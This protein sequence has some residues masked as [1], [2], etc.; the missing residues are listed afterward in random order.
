M[1]R[2]RALLSV[3]DKSGIEEFARGLVR[4]GWEV[5]S[6][7]G[8][9]RALAGAGLPVVQVAEVTSHPEMMDGRVKTLHPAVH[10]GI[11]ARGGN[12]DDAAAL[13]GQGYA[14]VGLVAVNLYPFGETVAKG[15]VSVGDAMEQVD[16]GGPTMIR[17]AA[18]NHADVW[19]VVDPADYPR[20]LAALD[21]EADGRALRRELAVKVFAHTSAYDDAVAVWLEQAAGRESGTRTDAGDPVAD[22][23]GGGMFPAHLALSAELE[24]TLRYGENPDQEA[25]FYRWRGQ[26]PIGLAGLEQL[27]GK[28]LSYNN[29]LDLDGALHCLAPFAFSAR[30]AVCIVKHTTPAGMALAETLEEAYLRAL[31]TDPVSAF[32]SVI[33]VNRRIDAATAGHM[34]ELFIECL[35]APAFDDE[36]MKILARKSGLRL[37]AMS[38]NP[39]ARARLPLDP[40]RVDWWPTASPARRTS[41]AFL[42]AH[43]R[44][45]E[46]RTLR[47]VSGG[48]LAQSVPSPPFYGL[49]S[50]EWKVV[51]RRTPSG[52]E[53][54][55]LDFAWSAVAGVKSNAILLARDGATLGIGMGQ[56]S[57]VDASELAVRKAAAAGLDLSGCALASDAFFPFRDGVDAAAAAGVRAIVQPGG[58]IRDEEVIAAADEHEVAMVFTGRRLFRH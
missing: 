36:A 38:G 49:E 28:A 51:T 35:V 40:D 2:R 44:L 45:P 41:A 4:R 57:R 6:T 29:Y 50:A 37:L 46:P 47:T 15:G 13:A 54:D 26:G 19:A 33:A 25:A 18:K 30:P 9:A 24:G 21:R 48:L 31:R 23:S 39:V 3:S 53:L 12:R 55:D 10:A 34:S 27:H 32:G 52:R 11:L 8:T 43:G 20:V 42:A 17:A 7:G 5:V 22:G 56:V 16:I 1:T 14:P 58:S